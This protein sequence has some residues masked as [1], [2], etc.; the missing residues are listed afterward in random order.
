LH[1]PKRNR[2]ADFAQSRQPEQGRQ[3]TSGTRNNL[4]RPGASGPNLARSE[5]LAIAFGFS[6]PRSTRNANFAAAKKKEGP[7]RRGR[8]IEFLETAPRPLNIATEGEIGVDDA[9]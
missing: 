1:R 3:A 9:P 8:S 7:R 2:A 6:V 4:A 5:P